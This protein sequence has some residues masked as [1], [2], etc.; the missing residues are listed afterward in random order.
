LAGF[1]DGLKLHHAH[2]DKFAYQDSPIHRL[3]SRVKFIAVV[4]FTVIVIALPRHSIVLLSLYAVGPF[5]IL[6]L[7]RIPLRFVFKQILLVSPFILMLALTSPFYEKTQVAVSFGP[8]SWTT[9][10][11]WLR[12]GN[13]TGKFVIT[14]MC[15]IAL[16]S[17][18]RFSDLLAGLQKL[19]VPRILV[20]QLGFL[21][22]YIFVVIDKAQH[23]LLSRRARSLAYLGFR[24]ELKTASAM[25]G[26]LFIR[27]ID[28]AER[29]S[30]AMQGRGFN[31][32]WRNLS[33]LKIKRADYIFAAAVICC[34]IVLEFFAKPL[35]M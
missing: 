23:M 1:F 9:T 24:T 11:G 18:T 12:C 20:L 35:F 2:I 15:M 25:I 34:V 13:I 16:V 32:D 14:I 8:W 6:V 10:A 26:S 7:G 27:S 33:H 30:T 17:T 19:G 22:R 28:S 21:Y 3:D 4:L 31:Q 29:V 5:A